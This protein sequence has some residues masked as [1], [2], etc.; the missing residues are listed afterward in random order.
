MLTYAQVTAGEAP[1]GGPRPA[2]PAGTQRPCQPHTARAPPGPPHWRSPSRHKVPFRPGQ[3]T[4][5]PKRKQSCAS[6][7]LEGLESLC[8]RWDRKNG[9]AAVEN[10]MAVPQNIKY[11]VTRG[12]SNPT[13]GS[14]P[15]RTESR[16]LERGLHA[17]P[18]SR[19]PE[20]EATRGPLRMKRPS[21]GRPF[22][23][24]SFGPQRMEPLTPA[25]TWTGLEDVAL[26]ETIRHRTGG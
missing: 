14:V 12:A 13:S 8:R 24:S 3:A 17:R 2:R 1:R 4:W 22:H 19:Q 26:G 5:P 6:K 7:D 16:N 25:T 11:R 9:A 15:E 20:V 18:P 10:R 23:G 21:V